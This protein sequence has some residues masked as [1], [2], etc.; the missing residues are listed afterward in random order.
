MIFVKISSPLPDD[1]LLVPVIR[2]VPFVEAG[3]L[4]FSRRLSAERAASVPV[5]DVI[6]EP[7]IF[8][9]FISEKGEENALFSASPRILNPV[10]RQQIEA[11]VGPGSSK[12]ILS[13]V[14][15]YEKVCSKALSKIPIYNSDHLSVRKVHPKRNLAYLLELYLYNFKNFVKKYLVP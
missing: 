12:F 6:F 5:S 13:K 8:E 4:R 3:I 11:V 9:K 1:I 14:C 7:E 10:V 2:I 15:G